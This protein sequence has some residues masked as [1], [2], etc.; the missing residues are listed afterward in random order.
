[1]RIPIWYK[2]D[3]NNNPKTYGFVDQLAFIAGRPMIVKYWVNIYENQ[4]KR[5]DKSPDAFIVFSPIEESSESKKYPKTNY[6]PKQE[7]VPYSDVGDDN[8]PF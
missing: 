2:V 5:S 4:N 6:K 3:A 8:D 1:M 7:D